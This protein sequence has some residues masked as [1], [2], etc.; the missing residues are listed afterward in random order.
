MKN[1]KGND[2]SEAKSEGTAGPPNPPVPPPP[3][4]A[5]PPPPGP[6]PPPPLRP[7]PPP[8]PPKNAP[9]PMAGKTQI[10]PKGN[11]KANS[12]DN[13]DAGSESGKTKLKPF[14]WDKVN[15]N[16]DQSMVWHELKEGSFQ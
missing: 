12:G 5:A 10:P 7:R 13:A 3:G 1:E 9:K 2:S 15:A 11:L 16:P 6:P 8:V 14:F 4:K